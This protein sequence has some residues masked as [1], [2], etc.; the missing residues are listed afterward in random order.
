MTRESYEILEKQL[1][2]GDNSGLGQLNRYQAACCQWL[3]RK[4]NFSCSYDDAYDVFVDSILAFRSNIIRGKYEFGNVQAYLNRI[5]WNKWLAT[6]RNRMQEN[7]KEEDVRRTMY[8]GT[9]NEPEGL[10][11]RE[12][13]LCYINK[14]MNQLKDR[15]IKILTYAIIDDMSM[16]EIAGKLGLANANVAKTTKSRCYKKLMNEI[17]LFQAK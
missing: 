14:A 4:S 10:E 3:I 15:C 12:K 6:S 11:A 1:M 17:K 2:L 13:K 9:E 16:K 5:C 7:K 8:T